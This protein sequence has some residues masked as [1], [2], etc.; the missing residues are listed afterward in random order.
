MDNPPLHLLSDA[1]AGG[2]GVY[3]YAATSTF[4]ASTY[5]TSYYWVDVVFSATP[6]PTTTTT[7]TV[8]V[9]TTTSTTVPPTT[10]STSTT[11]PGATTTST[12]VPVPTTTSTTTAVPTTTSTT[13]TTL[14]AQSVWPPSATPTVFAGADIPVELG[15]KFRSDVAGFISGI[16]FYKNALNTGTHTG[17]LWTTSGTRLAQATFTGETGSGWQQVTFS[18]PVAIA[19]NT[20]Y[21][22]SYFAPVGFYAISLD[23]FGT[24]GVDNP[25]LHLLSDAVGAGNGVYTYGATSTFPTSTYRTSYYWVD[26]V[27]SATPPPT[28]TT[29]STVPVPTTTSTTVPPTTTSTSTTVPGATTTSTTVPVPTTTSTT[30]AVPTTTSTS[31]TT[32][33]PGQASQTRTCGTAAGTNWATPNAACSNSDANAYSS[34]NNTTANVLVLSNFGFSIPATATVSGIGVRIL[35]CGTGATAADRRIKSALTVD[36]SAQ[37][38]TAQT[39]INQTQCTAFTDQTLGSATDT[40]GCGGLTPTVVNSANFGAR[41]WDNDTTAAELREQFVEVTVHYIMPSTT[42]TTTALPTTTSTTSTT[43]TTL[44]EQSIWPPSAT[45]TVF[46]GADVPVELG[47]K[48]RSDVAGFISGIRFY[49]NAQNTGTHTGSLWT[50]SGTRLAQATF[51]SET[52]S[53][54]QQVTFASPVAIAANTTY[55]ASYFAPVGFYAISLD[56]F[57]TAGVDNAPLHLLSNAV[58]GG[59]G[60][61]TYAATSTFP[62]ST[63]R[64]SYY[65]VDVLFSATALP[66]T[67]S[68]TSTT[69]DDARGIA[70]HHDD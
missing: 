11:V 26:V 45:P 55:I 31:T 28:T 59:N 70:D 16:R 57:A 29:T 42:T 17:S 41:I 34:F 40:W 48:F 44:P 24:G 36:A 1:V 3:T 20:T 37:C 53:G 7:S 33:I 30:T 67:T 56:F 64:S 47:V 65:W 39:G 22:A 19:A 2:N 5:R 6:P 69:I 25:P 62:T 66:T 61:Y 58:A 46:A 52:G 14:P 21:I 63:Y 43:T 32:T 4:P 15:V 68:T 60:I 38:G 49:K 9:P 27:F 50:T 23:F 51:T 35:G 18:S 8:P 54:W 10:T 12:T 13:T